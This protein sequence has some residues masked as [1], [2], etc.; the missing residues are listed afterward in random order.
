MGERT[1]VIYLRLAP[2]ANGFLFDGSTNSGMTRARV[3]DGK[4]QA[5]V[6]A[7]PIKNADL[8]DADTH[9]PKAGEWQVHAFTFKKTAKGTDVAH[10]LGDETKA[11]RVEA[12]SPLGGF[13]LGANVATKLGLACDVAEVIVYDRAVDA[14]ERNAVAEY[15]KERRQASERRIGKL[16][17]QAKLRIIQALRGVNRA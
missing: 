17:E 3:R 16:R 2:N 4:W 14:P 15:L 12:T 6:Q 7:P 5:G 10:Y 11:V 13:I 1:V 9:E 8:A